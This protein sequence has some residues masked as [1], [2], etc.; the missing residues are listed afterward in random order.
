GVHGGNPNRQRQHDGHRRM[1]P[2]RTGR[3]AEG[4]DERTCCD[5]PQALARTVDVNGYEENRGDRDERRDGTHDSHDQVTLADRGPNDLGQPES[6]RIARYS[7]Q[8]LDG[9]NAPHGWMRQG[10][11]YAERMGGLIGVSLVRQMSDEPRALLRQEP[12]GVVRPI[13]EA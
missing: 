11:P 7:G 6:D 12:R 9:A 4:R 2:E 13:V 10:A 1:Q 5:D 3:E 8:A